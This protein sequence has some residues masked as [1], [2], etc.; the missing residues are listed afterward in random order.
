MSLF[1]PLR[2]LHQLLD[3]LVQHLGV[4]RAEPFVANDALVV[5]QVD[6]RPALD[7]P[8]LRNGATFALLILERA[9][10]SLRGEL[11]R[12]LLEPQAGVFVGNI[13]AAV[14]DRLWEEVK[15]RLR[16]GGAMMV[17]NAANE[18]G[19]AIRIHAQAARTVEDFD[20]LQLIRILAG[21][22]GETKIAEQT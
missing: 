12:W 18:Q 19:F 3:G 13:S 4:G 7:I 11:T 15:C 17:H 9:P 6:S 22:A 1:R 2:L 16:G 20:G 21:K 10:T 8:G 14:R 5:E